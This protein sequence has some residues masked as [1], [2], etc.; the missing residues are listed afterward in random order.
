M[1]NSE[2]TEVKWKTCGDNGEYSSPVSIS[3]QEEKAGGHTFTYDYGKLR[4][5][6]VLFTLRELERHDWPPRQWVNEKGEAM[7]SMSWTPEEIRKSGSKW[8]AIHKL[9]ILKEL[10]PCIGT[11]SKI[12]LF[13]WYWKPLLE[14]YVTRLSPYPSA[15]NGL[16][17]FCWVK[18]GATKEEKKQFVATCISEGLTQD[19]ATQIPCLEAAEPKT[20]HSLF[21]DGTS[22]GDCPTYDSVAFAIRDGLRVFTPEVQG[23]IESFPALRLHLLLWWGWH[24]KPFYIKDSSGRVK[25]PVYCMQSLLEQQVAHMVAEG[26]LRF[27]DDLKDPLHQL[28]ESG[29]AKLQIL[30]PEANETAQTWLQKNMLPTVGTS[31]LSSACQALFQTAFS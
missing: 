19:E 3:G 9:V 28:S 31:L 25:W 27:N 29:K 15:P 17:P 2:T 21:G 6:Q 30:L 24:D 13:E 5:E 23:K 26:Y 10:E 11:W 12:D 18:G 1:N 20:W 14:E 16:P 7:P 4:T 8:L 22:V